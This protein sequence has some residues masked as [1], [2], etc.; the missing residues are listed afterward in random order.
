MKLT[1]L[2]VGHG[3]SSVLIHE[4]SAIIIDAGTGS[5]LLEFLVEQRITN[6]L[7]ILLS[8]ADLDH[9][10]GL[11]PLLS[12]G[13]FSIN[14]IRLNTDSSK[15]SAAWDDILYEIELLRRKH[16]LR[17]EP[18]LTTAQ[19]N[20]YVIGD[21]SIQ[22]L[23]PTPYL[24]ARGPGSVDRKRRKI[25]TNSISSVMKIETTAISVI[26]TGDIDIVGLSNLIENNDRI[27][28]NVLIFP[29][30]G[31]NP[32]KCNPDSFTRTIF[33]TFQ[34]QVVIMSIGRGRYS[35]PHPTIIGSLRE[36]NPSVRIMCTQISEHCS[37][38]L[39]TV[40]P[41]H[42]NNLFAFGRASNYCCAGSIEID[43][44]T[45]IILPEKTRHEDYIMRHIQQPLCLR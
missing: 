14:E 2:D 40:V 10:D 27:S 25:T 37:D 43:L 31:G 35:T 32:G 21:V 16:A 33:K 39:P 26:V 45:G 19:S 17:F 44:R 18:T 15:T 38:I 42:L 13:F 7:A 11:F 5:S 4:N 22:I 12:A 29:H 8:H 1:I 20:L 6:I 28:S 34:P 9:I 36:E 41:D 30:H 23:S 3:N 24:A